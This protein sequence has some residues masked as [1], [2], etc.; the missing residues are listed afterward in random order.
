MVSGRTRGSGEEGRKGGGEEEE[1]EEEASISAFPS[2]SGVEM[3]S[4]PF[5]VSPLPCMHSPSDSHLF[6]L[7]FCVVLCLVSGSDQK[8]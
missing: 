2:L 4:V 6:C 3:V 1:G 8:S 7:P 5:T